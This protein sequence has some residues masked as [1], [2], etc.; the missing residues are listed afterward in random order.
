MIIC[1]FCVQFLNG[2]CSFG[3]NRPRGMACRE[4]DP[5]IERFC[6]NPSDFVDAGQII[7]MATFFGI[8]GMELKRV[9]LIARRQEQLQKEQ[10]QQAR[11]SA[12]AELSP[13]T[14]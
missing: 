13:G 11:A 3:L 14:E 10:V 7:Q 6:A 12:A 1:E 9:K 4:F 8:K 2:E 5:G